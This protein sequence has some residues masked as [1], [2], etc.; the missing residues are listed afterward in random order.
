MKVMLDTNICIA[1]INQKSAKVLTQ[2]KQYK[3]G[4]V[5]ISAVTLAELQYGVAKSKHQHKNAD[6]LQQFILPLEVAV[7]DENATKKYGELRAELERKGTPIGALDMMIAAHALSLNVKLVT[8]NTKEF[9]RVK[10][11]ALLDWLD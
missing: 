9:K 5:C 10:Q 2:L 4:E 11:L 1:L 8:N 3:V 7:F 6:A